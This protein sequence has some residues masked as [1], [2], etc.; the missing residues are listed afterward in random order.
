MSR[1][2]WLKPPK[3][4]S[5]NMSIWGNIREKSLGQ[6]IRKEDLPPVDPEAERKRKADTDRWYASQEAKRERRKEA[7]LRHNFAAALGALVAMIFMFI[8]AYRES[9]NYILILTPIIG[10]VEFAL[11]KLFIMMFDGDD[12]DYDF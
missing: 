1:N 9:N 11:C 3:K 7:N 12:W 8:L 5:G 6:T 4:I 10:V 2:G